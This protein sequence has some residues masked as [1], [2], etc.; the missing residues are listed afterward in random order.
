MINQEQLEN[1]YR[2]GA[3]VR[4]TGLTRDDAARY[5]ADYIQFVAEFVTPGGR[6][7]DVGCGTG[8]ST[9]LFAEREYDA[10]GIDLNP[11]AFEPQARDRLRLIEGS[12]M[13]IPLLAAGFDAAAAYQSLEHVPDPK[14]MLAEMVRVVRPGGIVC[15]VGPNLLGLS[16]YLRALTWYVWRNRPLRTIVFRSPEMPRHPIGNTLPEVVRGLFVA[17]G[18]IVQKSLTRDATFSMREPDIR[19]PFWADNDATYLCNPLDLTRYFRGLGCEI[20][21]D[22]ALGRPGWT[23][24]LA[25]GTWVAIRTPPRT[26]P[27]PNGSIGER[28]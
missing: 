13:A 11:A 12:G 26:G 16:G 5:Y 3:G 20:L 10:T 1:L 19:P 9:D 4:T 24:M 8:W 18:R 2:S 28:S 15:V 22:A 21:R 6:V 27:E 14:R 7:L 17:L 25:G 23:R